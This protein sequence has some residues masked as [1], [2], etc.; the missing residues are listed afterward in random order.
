MPARS[1]IAEVS[2]LRSLKRD[3]EL[4]AAIQ[5][6][7]K[8]ELAVAELGIKVSEESDSSETM[9]LAN[10]E[11]A[12][13]ILSLYFFQILAGGDVC[14]LRFASE[15]IFAVGGLP[16]MGPEALDNSVGAGVS[17]WLTAT[18]PRLLRKRRLGIP[19][20]SGKAGHERGGRRFS[21]AV[22]PSRSHAFYDE[23][24]DGKLP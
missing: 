5:S 4:Y 3:D 22:R 20:R 10:V 17:R 18:L 9:E 24:L 21:R 15:L 1:I 23:E 11:R 6:Q 13:R 19:D 2:K 7:R 12:Q 8:T 14:L 16:A